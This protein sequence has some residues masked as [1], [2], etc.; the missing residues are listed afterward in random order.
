[1]CD[2]DALQTAAAAGIVTSTVIWSCYPPRRLATI[3][4]CSRRRLLWEDVHE[5]RPPATSRRLWTSSHLHDL[6]P[7]SEPVQQE[8]WRR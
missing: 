2:S 8:I 4:R 5:G 6:K 7:L 1:M 3:S